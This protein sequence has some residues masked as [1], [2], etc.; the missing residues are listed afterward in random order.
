MELP[1]S[2]HTVLVGRQ[3]FASQCVLLRHLVLQMLLSLVQHLKL[4]PQPQDRL[5]RRILLRGAAAKPA[6]APA[7]HP[8]YVVLGRN[9]V[10]I[11]RRMLSG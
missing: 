5:L 8:G 4:G 6:Q 11:G 1:E 3:M 7:G 10:W 9:C 2:S